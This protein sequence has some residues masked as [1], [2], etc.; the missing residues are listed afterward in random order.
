M[1]AMSLA[2][3]L[4]PL[5]AR[6]LGVLIEKEFTTP[7]QYP[8]SLNA[9]V[10]G[11]NQKS[12]RDPEM[13]VS[14]HEVSQAILRLRVAQLV[15]FV[16]LTGQRVEKYR[17]RSGGTL[18]LEPLDQAVMAEL[19]LRG[20]QQPNELARRVERMQPAATPESVQ[21]TLDALQRRQL[22]VQ[23][24]RRSGER[25]PRWMQLLAP[26]PGSRTASEARTARPDVG[27]EA[28]RIAAETA[29]GH[30]HAQGHGPHGHGVPTLT[31]LRPGV[32]AQEGMPVAPSAHRPTG[33]TWPPG[34][35]TTASPDARATGVPRDDAVDLAARVAVLETELASLRQ[36]V[37]ALAERLGGA[38][39]VG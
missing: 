13:S 14:E 37:R 36:Q 6:V 22:V 1:R 27:P 20:S 30:P 32:L 21:A 17:Q 9:L 12:N 5:E 2:I 31:G 18:H 35:A 15:E 39:R 4:D 23:Q 11:C 38:P 33:S 24:G 29:D 7:E 25:Y 8:L 16:Q 19:L 3:Q 26:V 34:E 28:A 10:N